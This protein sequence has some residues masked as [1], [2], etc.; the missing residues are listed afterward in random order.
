MYEEN[1]VQKNF[2]AVALACGLVS[3]AAFAQPNV[4]IYGVADIFYGYYK[5]VGG[6]SLQSLTSGGGGGSRLGFKGTEDLGGGTKAIFLLESGFNLD[7]GTAGQGGRLFGRQAYVGLQG[8]MGTLRAGRVQTPGYELTTYLDPI[9]LAPG[10]VLGG[11]TGEEKR[12]WIVNPLTDPGRMDNTLQYLSPT[13]N[14]AR[15]GY[16]HGFGEN[17]SGTSTNK[18]YDMIN[19]NYDQGPISAGYVYARASGTTNTSA[20]TVS[21][22]EHALAAAYDFNVVRLFA[23][24]QLRKPDGYDTDK[25]WQTGVSIPLTPVTTFRLSYGKLNNGERNGTN[26]TDT[27]WDA[28]AVGSS[29]TYTLS[30]RT[31]LYAFYKRTYNEGNAKQVTFPPGGLPAPTQLGA[32]TWDA[33][34]GLRHNF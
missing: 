24:Y 10:S 9:L 5:Q 26:A 21:V 16:L 31:M 17:A 15:F 13:W 7:T 3:G 4:E 34:F 12:V 20:A 2:R 1:M 6:P 19:A 30:K 8:T 11:L 18:N 32:I 23:S 28:K 22:Q 29:M 14:G 25:L 27:N 33:G